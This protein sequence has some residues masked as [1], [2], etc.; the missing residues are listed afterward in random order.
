MVFAVH[1]CALVGL[2]PHSVLCEVDLA[3]Q[4]PTF[5][6]VGLPSSVTQESRERIRAAVVNS[7]FEWPARKVT[8]NLLPA[9]LPKWGSH[10][11]L[12][13]ALGVLGASWDGPMPLNVFALGELS[14]SGAVKPCDWVLAIGEWLLKTAQLILEKGHEPMLVIAHE[15]DIKQLLAFDSRLSEL[16]ELA[17][18]GSLADASR[19]MLEAHSRIKSNGPQKTRAKLAIAKAQSDL[20]TLSQVQDE[21]LATIA[22]LTAVAGGHHCLFAGPHGMGKSMLIRAIC[23]AMAPLSD[24]YSA[25][26]FAMLRTFGEQFA[27][28]DNTRHTKPT[29]HLQSSIS[30]AAL[31]GSLLNSGQVLPGELTRAHLGTLVIDELLEFK[32]DVIEAFRQPLDEGI[33]RLQR[34]KFRT[35][36]PSK[37]QLLAS[38]NLC[39]CGYFGVDRRDCRCTASKRSAYQLKLSGPLMDRFDMMVV[40]GDRHLELSKSHIPRDLISMVVTLLDPSKWSERLQRSREAEGDVTIDPAEFWSQ[41][42]CSASDRGKLKLARVSKTIAALLN[43]KRNVNHLRMALLLRQDLDLVLRKQLKRPVSGRPI[44]NIGPIGQY[45]KGI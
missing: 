36:L 40:L 21:P 6:L 35:A 3:M 34:A 22:A 25:L 33:V 5:T 44:R 41:V 32:R 1:S 43:E 16:C 37:F 28:W 9:Q 2:E 31:E 39:P 11:E 19:A 20:T 12:A 38:T 26:R 42:E 15:N 24:Q 17:G 7:G 30:R 45:P 23:E 13:M 14:L 4:L 27:V 10:F 18:V 29:V 8:I